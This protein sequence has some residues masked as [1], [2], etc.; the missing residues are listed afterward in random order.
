MKNNPL[1][2]LLENLLESLGIDS[3]FEKMM[4][5]W[6]YPDI[7]DDDAFAANR[8]DEI[9][10]HVPIMGD[11]II[12]KFNV[13]NKDSNIQNKSLY[14]TTGQEDLYKDMQNIDGAFD[15]Q[16]SYPRNKAMKAIIEKFDKM[17]SILV[18]M[19]SDFPLAMGIG[20][21]FSEHDIPIAANK[22][23]QPAYDVHNI[24]NLKRHTAN[25]NRTSKSIDSFSL[26]HIDNNIQNKNI[27]IN[28]DGRKIGKM[29]IDYVKGQNL[30]LPRGRGIF[31]SSVL[32]GL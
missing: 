15:E 22:E 5:F 25:Q 6:N 12:R 1:K 18:E 19:H 11:S 7:I 8:P 28:I 9:T 13:F 3:Y 21:D 14:N 20:N 10:E 31:D 17:Q 23:I 16:L 27:D 26:P 29:V 4:R 24:Q 2:L 30:A 32:G